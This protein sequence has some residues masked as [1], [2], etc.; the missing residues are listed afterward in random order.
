VLER[1][2]RAD[3]LLLG[4]YLPLYVAVLCLHA[5]ESARSGLAQLPVF[6]RAVRGDYPVVAGYRLETDSSGSGLLPG[7]R[8]IRIGERDLRGEGYVGVQAIGLARTTPGRPVPLVFER[9]GERRE[10]PLEARPH[11]HP[12]SRLPLLLLIPVVCTLVVLRAPGSAGA[13]RFFLG[14]V[15]YAFAQAEFYGGPEWKSWLAAGVMDV[16]GPLSI[17]GMLHW[18]RRF[19][20]E[21]PE[22][23]RVSA[24]WPIVAAGLFAV[25]VRGSYALGWPVPGAWIARVSFAS[26]ALAIAAVLG[27]LG[28]NYR[29]AFAAGRRRLRWIL[30][31]AL[32]GSLPLAAALSAPLVAPGWEGFP[33]AFALGFLATGLGMSG[34]VLAV[35]RDNAFDVDRLIGATAAWSLAAG[36]AVVALAVVVPAAAGSVA[37]A[38]GVDPLSVRIGFAVLLGALA[39]PLGARLRPRIDQLLFPEREVL[40]EGT[41]R[42]RE[43]LVLTRSAGELLALASERA[44]ALVGAGGHALYRREAGAL[45]LA[46]AHGLALPARVAALPAKLAPGNAP[47]ELAAKGVALVVPLLDA[48]L[49]LAQ[50][51][52]GDIYTLT[53]TDALAAVGGGR[54][55]RE[56]AGGPREPC[57][58]EPDRRRE[59]RSPRAAAR[60][61]AARGGARRAAQRPRDARAGRAHRRLHAGPR[62]DAQLA[63]RPLEAR[64]RRGAVGA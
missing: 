29:H 12:W 61:R 11:R 39:V 9:G 55:A 30:L 14:F 47:A 60:G 51:R 45:C 41:E 2:S 37:G 58:D 8:L 52:S 53:D 63:P 40:R 23:A 21:M 20:D 7:D 22:A 62:R 19:P 28:W 35:V 43:D 33:Q 48:F 36:A 17:L 59:P 56:G 38:L 4:I 24:G 44:A 32:V 49:C 13:R 34:L 25:C 54:P 1:T 6:A 31:G 18:T 16:A 42:L 26:H 10:V 27:I 46:S 57:Q 5:H 50:K 3:R 15:T 64:C